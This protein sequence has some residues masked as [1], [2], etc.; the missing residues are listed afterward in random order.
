MALNKYRGKGYGYNNVIP[1]D[2][3]IYEESSTQKAPIGFKLEMNDGRVFRYCK[4]GGTALDPGKIVQG[5]A[6][7]QYDEDCVVYVAAAIGDTH[8]HLTNHSSGAAKTKDALA[9]GFITV[10]AGSSQLGRTYKIKG[11]EAAAANAELIVYLY[12]PLVTA[13]STT[14]TVTF[15]YCPYYATVLEAATNRPIGVPLC[16]SVTANYYYWC[17]TRGIV[18]VI[19]SG[20]ITAGDDLQVASGLVAVI[21]ETTESR[22]GMALV[23]GD[24][25]DSCLVWLE[26]E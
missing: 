18:G 19:S 9:D 10:G 8:I 17:Q 5:P 6:Q 20:T 23:S 25:G 12:D 16:N 26:L 22:V 1:P 4:N 15:A 11:N 7:N 2:Q 24:N 13:I 3:G 21:A 14:S